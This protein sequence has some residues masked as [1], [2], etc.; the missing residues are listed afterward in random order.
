VNTG[1][2]DLF[3]EEATSK[4]DNDLVIYLNIK[5]YSGHML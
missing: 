2:S 1:R 3:G 5:K 4:A